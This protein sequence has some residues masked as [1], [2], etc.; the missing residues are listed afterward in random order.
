VITAKYFRNAFV[1]CI[2]LFFVPVFVFAE[3]FE[4][5]RDRAFE[6]LKG[7]KFQAAPLNE[8]LAEGRPRYTRHYSF[9]VVNFALPAL[10]NDEQNRE[11][12]IALAN[13][14]RFY[15]D[16]PRERNDRDNLH[17][18][19][20]ILGRIVEFYGQNGSRRVLLNNRVEAIMY[21]L[22]EAYIS[23]NSF[24]EDATRSPFD[25]GIWQKWVE[26]PK[27]D[28]APPTS[29]NHHLMKFTTLW[30][31]S[32]LLSEHPQ[33]GDNK[34]NGLTAREHFNA[35][36]EYAKKYFRM[37]GNRGLFIE[38]ANGGYGPRSLE[39]IYTL[40]DFADDE[41][42]TLAGNTLTM[43]WASWAQEQIDGVRGGGRARTL[44]HMSDRVGWDSVSRLAYYYTGIGKQVPPAQEMLS[45]LTSDYRMPQVVID[46]AVDIEGRGAYE[47]C[48]RRMGLLYSREN[49]TMGF[50]MRQD[51]G[52][53]LRYSYCTPGF[54]MGMPIAEARSYHDWAIMSTMDRWQGVIFKGHPDAR[55]VPQMRAGDHKSARQSLRGV[56]KKGTMLVERLP[57]PYS[58]GLP[59]APNDKIPITHGS[60]V[61]FSKFG[62]SNRVE[63]GGWVFTESQDA[64]AA[65]RPSRG[66]YQWTACEDD[67]PNSVGGRIEG[68]WMA[69]HD[70]FAP[71][72]IEVAGKVDFENY[73]KFQNTILALPLEWKEGLLFYTSLYGDNFTFPDKNPDK[74]PTI[75]DVPV[76]QEFLSPE[77]LFKS[78][79]IESGWDSGIIEIKFKGEKI[80]LDFR[81]TS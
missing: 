68:D 75:N 17:W 10:W 29:E 14:S 60:R 61:W 46:I 13:H 8:P 4:S 78:P 58:T 63:R 1:F 36:N 69:M 9:S 74:H 62:L 19:S 37:R 5:R 7:R 33:Y 81:K 50:P 3:D 59:A 79:F 44:Q 32:K 65:V 77:Y 48:D 2:V 66:K 35:W 31:F 49:F 47:A 55:I 71:I 51:F 72:I 67:R 23:D 80:V 73:E 53:I 28:L 52:G 21:E 41:L 18:V 54:I 30:H 39:G 34:Y 22:I 16:N 64:Y 20:L 24:I 26:D 57:S 42:K 27:Y 25:I 6:A 38:M 12:N 11:A 45:V 76:N 70:W 56:Q 40:Y 15:L 43:Y